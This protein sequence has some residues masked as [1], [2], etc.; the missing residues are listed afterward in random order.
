MH[1]AYL[2]GRYP[3]ISHT[4]IARE[5]RALRALGVRIDTFSIWPTDPSLLLSDADREDFETTEALLS[6]NPRR[7][8]AAAR[9]VLLMRPGRLAAT[10]VEALRL[11]RPGLRGVGLSLTWVLEAIVL[12]DI[13][14][15]RRIT[16]VHAHI[17]GTAPVVALLVSKLG[18]ETYTRGPR[19]TWSMTVHGSQEFFEVHEERLAD[20]VRAATFVV[21]ISDFTRSQLMGLV[22]ERNWSKLRVVHCGVDLDSFSPRHTSTPRDRSAIE[23]L[24]VGRLTPGKGQACLVEALKLCLASPMQARLTIVGEGPAREEIEGVAQRLGVESHVEL[25]GAVGQDD[26]QALYDKA[27]I[28]ALSSF[29][30]GVPIVLMEAMA[31]ELPVVAPAIMGIPELIE[32]GV[33]GLLTKPARA[34][35]IADCVERLAADPD[36]SA[37][38]GREGRWAVSERFDVRRSAEKLFDIFME[39]IEPPAE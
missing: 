24:T 37:R 25:T 30:E 4:F 13:C 28:F 26:I 10:L 35:Q 15:A 16:H 21:C 9:R 22:E 8:A 36:L 12:W 5:V 27:D 23:I 34:D 14:R 38:L 32:D 7:A 20:K 18:D 39:F 11:R 19:W 31:K 17:N 2:T 29:A 3:A 1:I 33:S 6:V